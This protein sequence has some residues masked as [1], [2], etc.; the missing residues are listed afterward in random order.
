MTSQWYVAHCKL[1]KEKQAAAALEAHLG[2]SVYLPEVRRQV[3]GQVQ[4]A[5]FFPGYLFVRA[6]LQMVAPSDIHT[7]PGV[8]RLVTFGEVPQPVPSVVIEAIRRQVKH[9]KT[10]GGLVMHGFRP[11]DRVRLTEGPLHGLEAIF[12]GPMKP[13]ERVRVLIEFLGALRNMDVGVEKLERVGGTAA[14]RPPRRTRGRGR[15]IRHSDASRDRGP[16]G[17]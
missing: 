5:P 1:Q 15:I 16:A 6:N 17:S 7:M 4:R 9:L 11:G 12:L 2:L 10:Q 3:H 13:S 14:S 8:L